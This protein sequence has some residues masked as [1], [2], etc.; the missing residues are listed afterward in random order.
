M[1]YD[2]K[3]RPQ[4]APFPSSSGPVLFRIGLL[5]GSGLLLRVDDKTLTRPKPLK[6]NPPLFVMNGRNSRNMLITSLY[7]L[8]E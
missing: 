7:S 5:D 6:R 2:P 8:A 4:T 1:I 3:K